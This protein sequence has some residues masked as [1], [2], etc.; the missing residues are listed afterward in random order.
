MPSLL[1]LQRVM[2]ESLLDEATGAND[3]ALQH[4][5]ASGF[6]PAQRLS[7]HRNTIQGTL[8]RALGL[9]YPAVRWIVGV[10]LFDCV[11][12]RFM[13]LHAPHCADLNAYGGEFADFLQCLEH[14]AAIAYLA[15]VARLEWA[16]NRALHA[17]QVPALDLSQLAALV[18]DDHDRI[19]FAAHPSLSL[20]HSDYPIDAIWRAV[21]QRDDTAMAAID[22]ADGP[23][24]L[25]VRRRV[26]EIEVLRLVEPEWRFALALVDGQPLGAALGAQPNSQAPEWL[27]RHLAEG[28][29]ISFYLRAG[30][31]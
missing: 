16:V 4:I 23:V 2:C 9:S 7:I 17:P 11:A 30:E 13:R 29:F 3:A 27:A 25:L 26:D 31:P 15:D 28:N 24:D 21:L 14:A 10:E 19:R 18:S 1:E 12:Q 22:L 8:A 6:A 20:L 5:V